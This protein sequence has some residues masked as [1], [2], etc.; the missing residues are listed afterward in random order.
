MRYWLVK[1]EPEDY[2]WTNLLADGRTSW[3]GVRSYPARNH[4]R[5]MEKG[6]LV[7]F[8]HSVT[9]K[10]AVG[11]ARVEREAYADPT[12][13]EGDW[14]CVDIVP[15]KPLKEPVT[16]EQ[17]RADPILSQMPFVKQ[18]RLSVSPVTA[19]QFK[20]LLKLAETKL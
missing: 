5:G 4:L 7:F 18:S 20:Q 16:L 8:Y 11:L 2:S 15:V 19:Q 14:S 3:T 12:A 6:D 9:D 17:I 1:Q 10:Q 13:E